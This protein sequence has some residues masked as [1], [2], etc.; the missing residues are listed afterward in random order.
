MLVGFFWRM[1]SEMYRCA[2]SL[3]WVVEPGAISTTRSIATPV[4]RLSN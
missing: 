1:G 2:M 4:G 3:W